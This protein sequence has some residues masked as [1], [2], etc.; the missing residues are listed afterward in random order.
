MRR[1][2]AFWSKPY[3]APALGNQ[4]RLSALLAEYRNRYPSQARSE[5]EAVPLRVCATFVRCP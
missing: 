4:A 5:A 1:P 2:S 3:L